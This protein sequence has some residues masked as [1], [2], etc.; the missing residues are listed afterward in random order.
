MLWFLVFVSGGSA[1]REWSMTQFI[2]FEPKQAIS[3]PDFSQA[4]TQ[5]GA[6]ASTFDVR[7]I[8]SEVE[9]GRAFALRMQAY[10]H[11]WDTPPQLPN[12]EYRDA[13][14]DQR[15]T[16]QMG[17]YDGDRLV[18]AMRLC[19]SPPSDPLSTMPCAEYYPALLPIKRSAPSSLMEVSRFSIDPEISNTSYRTTLYA[20]LVRASLMA[21]Q[22][23]DVTM[24]LIATVPEWVRFYKFMLGFE[25]IGEPA[26]YAPA[27]YKISLLGGTLAQ[28]ETRQRLQNKFFR[29]SKEEIAALRQTLA[30][31]LE[32]V[33]AA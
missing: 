11:F 22:A 19:F 31:I 15:T 13:Y 14:D 24:I 25:L 28:A 16:V 17:A 33:E 29:I 32:H 5:A 8:T 3:V 12:A 20:S 2:K 9:R 27:T 7:I 4:G 6:T 30:P 26:V 18:G 1:A 23:A 10:K 21:A